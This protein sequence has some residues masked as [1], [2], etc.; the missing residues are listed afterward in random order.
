MLGKGDAGAPAR[1]RGS[2]TWRLQGGRSPLQSADTK[3]G[4]PRGRDARPGRGARG[5]GSLSARRAN[6]SGPAPAPP[7]ARAP[8]PPVLRVPGS[9]APP[10][11]AIRVPTLPLARALCAP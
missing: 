10:G 11:T 4:P 5:A 6:R 1:A 8:P 3:P 7:P 9:P 2:L